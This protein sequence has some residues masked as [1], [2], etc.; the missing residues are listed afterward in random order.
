MQKQLALLMLT[1]LAACSATMQSYGDADSA[2]RAADP[3]FAAAMNRTD[4][5]TV[6]TYY[7]DDAVLLPPNAPAVHG[8]A[9][10]QSFW[11]SLLSSAKFRVTLTPDTILH[12]GDLATEVGHYDL[13]ITPPSGGAS[14]QDK[15][16]YSV[17]WRRDADG[18]WRIAVDMFS[19]DNP[20]PPA[21]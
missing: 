10:I 6:M 12:S 20:P 4:M 9:A 18:R 16:K 15:G 14:M 21:R 3:E 7:A 1:L 8:K 11:T 17:T 19:S 5:P 13:A 2:I